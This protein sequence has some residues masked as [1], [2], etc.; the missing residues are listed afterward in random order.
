MD[1]GMN[2]DSFRVKSDNILQSNDPAVAAFHMV[3]K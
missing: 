3:A 1:K 2:A